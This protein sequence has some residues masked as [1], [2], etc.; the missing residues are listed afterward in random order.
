[1]PTAKGRD[2]RRDRHGFDESH[3]PVADA[4]GKFVPQSLVRRALSVTLET[5]RETY[6]PGDDVEMTVT[7]E[8]RLPVPVVLETPTRRLW[9]W[10]V[11]GV[12]EASDE[13]VFVADE[14][15]TL[16]F[17]AGE[18]K[19]LTHVWHGSFKRTGDEGETTR[20]VEAE[21]GVHD[22]TA[23]VAVEGDRPEDSVEIR[24]S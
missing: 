23:F 24:I 9:G 20:W 5:D 4:V 17:R 22:V 10:S 1:M 19:V 13:R 14:P 12:P 2:E 6:A 3:N 11:D 8:N 21:P 7:I 15:G 16:A 18:R